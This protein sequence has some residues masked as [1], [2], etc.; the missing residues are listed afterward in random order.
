MKRALLLFSVLFLTVTIFAQTVAPI[1]DIQYTTDPSG[2]SPYMGQQVITSGVVVDTI[3]AGYWIQDGSGPWNGIYVFDNTNFPN[4]GDDITITATVDE[5]YNLTELKTV[6]SF[7][8]N[9]T[10]NTV[11]P[12]TVLTNQAGAEQYESVLVQVLN[13]QCVNPDAGFGMWQANDGSGIVLVDDKL[14]PF[15]AIQGVEYDVTG[16]VEYSFSEWKI[17]PTVHTDIELS[18]ADISGQTETVKVM[19]YN[20]LQYPGTTADRSDDFRTIMHDA[21]PDLILVNELESATGADILLNNALNTNGI[22]YYNRATFVN[23]TDTDNM[24]FYNNNTFGLA[25]QAVISTNLRDINH[26]KVFYKS[27]DLALGDTTFLNLFSCHLKASQGFEAE[28]LAEVQSFFSYL[29]SQGNL[30]N[31]ILGGD[32]NFY[33]NINET[34]YNEI[35]NHATYQLLDPGGSGYWHNK[36]A[37]T[38]LHSQSTRI[39]IGYGGG[40][41]EGVDDRF[42]FIF[43]ANDFVNATN[44]ATYKSGSYRVYGNDGSGNCYNNDINAIP[45]TIYSQAVLDAL[46][47][48]S[49]H[50][51]VIAEFNIGGSVALSNEAEILSFSLANQTGPATINSGAATVSIEVANGTALTNLSPTIT[52]S[53]NA[54]INPASGVSQDFTS[55]VNYTVTAQDA[56][57]KTWTVTVT[58]AA[59]TALTSIYDIEYTT[60]PLGNSPYL[61]MTVVTSGTVTAVTTNAYWI[62]DGPGSWNGL[63]VYDPT[64]SPSVGDHIEIAG[65]VDEYNNLTELKT[66]TSLITNSTGNT[67]QPVVISTADAGTEPYENVLVTLENA[68][69]VNSNAG[70]GMWEVDDGSGIILIDDVLQVFVPVTGNFYTITGPAFYSYSE[71]KVLPRDLNDITVGI[72]DVIH[73]EFYISPNPATNEVV[74]NMAEDISDISITDVLGKTTQ[75]PYRNNTIDV[76]NYENGI[77]IVTIITKG[78]EHLSTR[79]I[80]Q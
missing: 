78:G 74:I 2:N 5:Y 8:L 4:P 29:Q 3:A 47:R 52:V 32:F 71:R 67:V 42:D 68:Q 10:G 58:E 80:K 38:H 63:Y 66:I 50:M 1:Y 51:P 33:N 35:V 9:S 54:S 39:N 79:L 59:P 12:V 65:T 45:S 7:V 57:T 27:A 34:A 31:V 6:T 49:D 56:S 17:L 61:G 60:D 36:F 75:L 25:S 16:I 53:A 76:S 69:C 18:V 28:R 64:N 30:E 70:F 11:L 77:Y 20:I 44:N 72:R 19:Y 62:Q 24:L 55:A 48:C 23:G 43:F 73:E 26:Y 13:S 15:T 41:G 37:L 14:Y 46:F 40:I 21:L 22:S